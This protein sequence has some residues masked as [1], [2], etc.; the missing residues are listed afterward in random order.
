MDTDD[1]FAWRNVSPDVNHGGDIPAYLIP[2]LNNTELRVLDFGCGYGELLLALK[3]RGFTHIEGAD[4]NAI[5]IEHARDQGL[6]VHDLVSSDVFYAQK[7][8]QFDYVVMSHVLEHFSKEAIIPQLRRIRELLA[9][10]G[11]LI[12]MVPNAQ[13]HTGCYW[14][15]EDFTHHTIFT[16][17]SLFYVLKAAG[18]SFVEFIDVD[19]TVGARIRQR[20]SR[21]FWLAIYRANINF[22]NWVTASS[23]HRPS[24]Q[25]F[26]YE[27]KALARA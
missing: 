9:D 27:I 11:G 12:V 7:R 25:I 1:Y 4:I 22:W 2:I 5:A 8:G 14:A 13:S 19:C 17:G 26:S 15:Y 21:R 23:F 3:R 6:N 10:D 16:A 24:V 20:I 18:F